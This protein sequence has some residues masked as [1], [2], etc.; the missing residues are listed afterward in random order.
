MI[1]R[2][3]DSDKNEAAKIEFFRSATH[4]FIAG[5]FSVISRL[6]PVGGNLLHHAVEM[7]LKGALSLHLSNNDLLKLGHNLK[8]LWSEFKTIFCDPNLAQFD[9]T[10][11]QLHRFERLRY[12]D[13]VLQ[14]GME[15]QFALFRGDLV[16]SS[17][18]T[19]SMLFNYNLVLEDIDHLV[20]VIFEQ[21]HVNP[22][23]YLGV[24][25]DQAKHF[26][27]LHNTYPLVPAI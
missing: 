9:V 22:G 27:S 6:F 25:G 13:T 5:R 18:I 17:N 21:A 7:Y 10:V 19:N 11:N 14:E 24:I 1:N 20:K 3:E 15:G 16:Q 26:L 4:Y 12:P 8:K 2:N 23:F